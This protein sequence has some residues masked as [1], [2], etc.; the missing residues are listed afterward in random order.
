MTAR[1]HAPNPPP[2]GKRDPGSSPGRRLFRRRAPTQFLPRRGRGTAPAGRGGGVVAQSDPPRRARPPPALPSSPRTCSGVPLHLPRYIGRGPSRAKEAGPRVKPG[3]T[4]ISKASA[5]SNPPPE[6]EGDR[7]RRAWWRG[8]RQ[9][10]TAAIHPRPNHPPSVTP[11][12]LRGPATPSP[13][14]TPRPSD[15]QKKRDPGA[16]PG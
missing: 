4:D 15:P 14:H 16:S 9:K 13:V 1:G 12:L 10:R 2:E 8:I 3:V 11:D 7:A 6:G 5:H